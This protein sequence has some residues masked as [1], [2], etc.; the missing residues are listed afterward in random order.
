MKCKYCR[1]CRKGF[2]ESKPEAYVCIGVKEP[3]VITDIDCDCTEYVDRAKSNK[4]EVVRCPNCNESYYQELYST[5]TCVYSPN[6]YKN[7]ELISK[8]SNTTRTVCRCL[9]CLN[10]FSYTSK[11]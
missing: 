10:E 4:I 8:S 1:S 6:I 5:T 9:N 2:F 7:G 3:F 11:E